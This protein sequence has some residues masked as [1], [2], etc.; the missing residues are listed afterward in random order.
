MTETKTFN[1]PNISCGHC[2][3]TIKREVS[4]VP[5]VQS[6]DAEQATKRVTVTWDSRTSWE[7]IKETLV[8]IGYPPAE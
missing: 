4:A 7:V 6:V 1:V 2:V 5:G 8:E 3:M